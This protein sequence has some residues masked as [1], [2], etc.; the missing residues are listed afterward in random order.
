MWELLFFF[1]SGIEPRKWNPHMQCQH[2]TADNLPAPALILRGCFPGKSGDSRIF[3]WLSLH[4]GFLSFIYL[5]VPRTSLQQTFERPKS[6][7]LGAFSE[8]S[9][10]ACELTLYRLQ[11]LPTLSQ[12][13]F[14]S[15]QSNP[16]WQPSQRNWRSWNLQLLL[17]WS[18]GYDQEEHYSNRRAGEGIL[19]RKGD[20]KEKEP[21]GQVLTKVG[22]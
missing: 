5:I 13:G 11:G 21:E 15:C 16:L 9:F 6:D 10:Q 2:S 12:T 4:E 3:L 8:S 18:L 7:G 17:M 22:E 20:A 14:C 1:G 19:L